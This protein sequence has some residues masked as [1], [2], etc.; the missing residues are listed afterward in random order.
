[1]GKIYVMVTVDWEGRRWEKGETCAG[2]FNKLRNKIEV[3]LKK[4]IPITHFICPTYDDNRINRIKMTNNGVISVDDEIGLHVHC[5]KALTDGANVKFK[6][7]PDFLEDSEYAGTGRGVPLGEYGENEIKSIIGYSKKK[8]E[9]SFN[10][11]DVQSFRCGG[12]MTSDQVFKGLSENGFK[13]DSS[14]VPPEIF[15]QGYSKFKKGNMK[16]DY[17]D[18]NNGITEM[19]LKLWGYD[20]ITNGYMKNCNRHESGITCIKRGTQ[21][22]KMNG[23]IE[24]PNNYGLIDYSSGKTTINHVKNEVKKVKMPFFINLGCHLEGKYKND[25]LDLL[26]R[27]MYDYEFITVKKAGVI[28]TNLVK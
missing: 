27:E 16:D 9:E 19:L 23:I 1:M 28:Y 21:P 18:T 8:L 25:L 12:W 20:K 11:K 7:K 4:E 5:W 17:G 6:R 14:A 13:Y 2:D 26:N 24:I 3:Q 15:S 10:V 22:F